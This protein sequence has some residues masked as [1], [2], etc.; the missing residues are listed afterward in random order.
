MAKTRESRGKK[1][2]AG[3]DK[4]AGGEESLEET[5]T[6]R[7][8]RKRNG[9]KSGGGGA[10]KPKLADDLKYIESMQQGMEG[11]VPVVTPEAA[12][13]EGD[14]QQ[15]EKTLRS[16][17]AGVHFRLKGV[18]EENWLVKEESEKEQNASD[19]DAAL[20]EQIYSEFLCSVNGVSGVACTS[21]E[22]LQ[23]LERYLMPH[24]VTGGEANEKGEIVAVQGKVTKRKCPREKKGAAVKGMCSSNAHVLSIVLMVNEK[25][26][27]KVNAWNCMNGKAFL[28]FLHTV[29][30]LL[31]D[32]CEELSLKEEIHLLKFL[33]NCVK[34]LEHEVVRKAVM[35]LFSIG[36]WRHV[37]SVR[38]E[39]EAATH[40]LV[41]RS[42]KIYAKVEGKASDNYKWQL[43]KERTFFVKCID[44]FF[45]VLHGVAKEGDNDSNMYCNRF[46]ELVIDLMSQLP[47]RRYFGTFLEDRHFVL[48]CDRSLLSKTSTK[49]GL[50]RKQ[51]KT[52]KFYAYF[53]IDDFSGEAL[54]EQKVMKIHYERIQELQRYC[55]SNLPSKYQSFYFASIASCDSEKA[56]VEAL[57]TLNENELCSLCRNFGISFDESPFDKSFVLDSIAYRFARK[58][59]EIDTIDAT[60]LY[61]TE[62]DI[63][64]NDLITTVTFQGEK[65]LPLPKL[66][67]QFLTMRDYLFRNFTLFKLEAT[68]ELRD[69]IEAAVGRLYFKHNSGERGSVVSSNGPLKMATVIENFTI[70]EVTKPK[71]GE[72]TPGS[73]KAD[74]TINL[75]NA[76]IDARESWNSLRPFDVLY[77]VSC[78]GKVEG[79]NVA[80][81]DKYGITCAR[82]GEVVGIV[83][84]KGRLI[85][86]FENRKPAMH[87]ITFRVVLDSMQYGK[88]MKGLPLDAP[89]P[90]DSFNVVLRR[91]PEENNFKAVLE[92]V[93]NLLKTDCSLP[94]WLQDVFLGYGDPTAAS[95][96]S[97]A[98]TEDFVDFGYTFQSKSHLESCFPS[99]SVEFV[100]C[101]A[102]PFAIKFVDSISKLEVKNGSQ[103]PSFF[104]P[105]AAQMNR[106]AFTAKQSEALVSAMHKGLTLVVGPPGTGKTDVAVRI[107]EN[108]YRNC[109]DEK[110]LI[111][112]HSNQALNQLF[113]KI[114]C[115]DIEPRHL[116]RLGHGH[117][118]MELEDNFGNRGRVD[119]VL[120]RRLI[121]LSSVKALSD[122]LQIP[123]EF[124][125]SCESAIQF[126][127]SHIKPL[128]KRQRAAIASKENPYNFEKEFPFSDYLQIPVEKLFGGK[129]VTQKMDVCFECFEKMDDMFK[130]IE[131]YR[132]FEILT[133][134]RE[135]V[136][137]LLTKQARIIAM[138][139][140][141]AALRRQELVKLKFI[142]SNVLVE[143]AGQISE[144]ESFIP[145][146][147]QP[148]TNDASTLSR[149]VMLGDH[150]QLPPIIKNPTFQ[151]YSNMEQSFFARMVR[152]G[153]PVILLDKQGRC[154]TK[155]ADLFRWRYPSLGDLPHISESVPYRKKNPG[156]QFDYQLLDVNPPLSQGEREPFPH[157][158]QNSDEADF[159]VETY[160]FMR[161]SGYPSSK[162]TVLTTY[163]GQK[164]LLQERFNQKCS[165][166]PLYGMPSK[167]STVDK[168]QGQQNDYVLLSL[169]RT[170]HVGHIRDVRRLVVGMSRARFGLYVFCR[171]SVF[172]N[173]AELGKVVSLLSQHSSNLCIE[174]EYAYQPGN[175]R[176][177]PAGSY[178]EIKS[179]R[180]LADI[181]NANAELAK[182]GIEES[183]LKAKENEETAMETEP[184]KQIEEGEQENNIIPIVEELV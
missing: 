164:D 44:R 129:T 41:K 25:I 74:V 48:R 86:D 77:F 81:V 24:L 54:D 67:L 19:F 151:K 38:V 121:L 148:V 111:V 29:L 2:V 59:V 132:P 57:T 174:T 117:E 147:L 17:A 124:G 120:E 173:C 118:S 53:G 13:D 70:V 39:S 134:H 66:N 12:R 179:L 63:W 170:K 68:S 50:F 93:R 146:V 62:A 135:R 7:A 76:R 123:G 8:A 90:Y 34:S 141:Y 154:R 88:D 112:T 145:L 131:E 55:Y 69:S 183:R 167:I 85:E 182:R 18:A 40:R 73:V 37:N 94:D 72:S 97:C 16:G 65:C 115:S 47:T 78:N 91:K 139:C 142:Y 138:T 109:K 126:Y 4:G 184:A 33:T 160:K 130:E 58:P 116:V 103:K 101:E 137:F 113:E 104:N 1:K 71:L 163:N 149:V 136:N 176:P 5:A 155:I 15:K 125:L 80:F 20:V 168:Y 152:L 106:V 108:W 175:N 161:L 83:N 159:I 84:E 99:A 162:I 21:L 46:V 31:T 42:L 156:F 82:G 171:K 10:K 119:Y 102:P 26:R 166:S 28:P 43:E 140:T 180:E 32:R 98:L 100:G 177:K 169:V 36:L 128:L 9:N 23:Y 92:T 153:T 60:P 178:I 51:V 172:E 181:N 30:E 133:S 122:S 107:I 6:P 49:E 52:L 75:N 114:A 89:S 95:M 96:L 158:F 56:I 87:K 27:Q 64:N 11:G 157:V 110:I 79:K 165:G 14:T 35:R 22:G 3:E 45:S 105:V 150:N 144:I 61:P 127:I 143:E